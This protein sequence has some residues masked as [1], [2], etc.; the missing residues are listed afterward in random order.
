MKDRIFAYL[1][2]VDVRIE[3]CLFPR[4]WAGEI[5]GLRII[6]LDPRKDCLP[7]LIH[8]VIH[9]LEPDWTEEQVVTREDWLANRLTVNEWK[10]LLEILNSK[11]NRAPAKK[12]KLR[13]GVR[14]V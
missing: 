4:K 5:E 14:I 11:I 9:A 1:R 12:R 6:R 2:G 7:T 3:F 10:V 8:E 13:G